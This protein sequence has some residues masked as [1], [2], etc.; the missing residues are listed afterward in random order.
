MGQPHA[1]IFLGP[2]DFALDDIPTGRYVSNIMTQALAKTKL[3]D[4]ALQV[5]RSKGYSATTVDDICGAAGVSKGAFFHHFKGKEELAIAATG[6]WNEM[7]GEFF[8]QAPYQKITDPRERVLAYIDFRAAIL[9]GEL[10]DYTC[11]LG[12]MV[13][14]TFEAH[15]AIRDACNRGIS[16]HAH[17]IAKMLAEAKALYA[18]DANWKPESLALYTQAAIQGA[19]ILAKAK[20]GSKIA[21]ECIAYLRNH[22]EFLLGATH[23]PKPSAK[24]RR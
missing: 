18:P 20:G 2:G 12:T 8:A 24:K 3:L 16:L 7:T 13:Q 11:L 19:F 21:K 6:H 22:L 15:P 23:T 14:E 4:A 17:T 10:P 9:Q 5:I 1:Q